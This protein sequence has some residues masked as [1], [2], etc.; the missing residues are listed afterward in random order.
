MRTTPLYFS[1]LVATLFAAGIVAAQAAGG[2]F[3]DPSNAASP[4]G[5]TIGYQLYLTIGC[6]ARELLGKPC[7][8]PMAMENSP[9]VGD[10]TAR[11]EAVVSPVVPLPAPQPMAIATAESARFAPVPAP[12]EEYCAVLDIQFEID[13]DDIQREVK[14]KLAVLATFMKKYPDTS[15][16]IEGHTDDVGTDAHNMRLSQSRA[17]SVVD[18]LVQSLGIAPSRLTAVGYG[19]TRPLADNASEEG[20]RQNRRI[21]AVIGCVTDIAGLRVVPARITMALL[22]EFD[23]NQANI[24]PEYTGGL[25]KVADFMQENPA[26]T[27]TVEGHTGNLQGTPELAMEISQRRA[28][29]V[30]NHLVDNFGIARSRLAAEGFGQTRRIAY[31]TSEEGR[32]DNR[33]VNVIFNFAK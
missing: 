19:E 25:R 24:K 13:R 3:Y 26:V 33:R 1:I 6:P 32:Q 11:A 8:A 5:K 21:D 23:R 7:P 18:Y 20:K 15:A 28:Q 4:T 12:T 17:D 30:V 22:I 16:V 27:A 31:N 2:L 10:K 29:N 14:E 9:P